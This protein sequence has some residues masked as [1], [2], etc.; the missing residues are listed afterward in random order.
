MSDD[1]LVEAD[2]LQ[3]AGDPLGE[4]IALTA[5]LGR[6]RRDRDVLGAEIRLLAAHPQLHTRRLL[7]R[8]RANRIQLLGRG[9]WHYEYR[10]RCAVFHAR[11]VELDGSTDERIA[12]VPLGH[13]VFRPRDT[14]RLMSLLG[15]EA[16][17]PHEHLVLC[18]AHWEACGVLPVEQRMD[19]ELVVDALVK[20][21]NEL[22]LRSSDEAALL[23]ALLR[24]LGE[25]SGLPPAIRLGD[26][27]VID[28]SACTVSAAYDARIEQST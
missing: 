7:T 12:V 27:A 19:W 6:D 10:H 22:R 26:G 23:D 8:I 24:I 13:L 28:M 14:A 15:A 21:T 9:A 1:V 16:A 5:A 25:L 20:P 11:L 17:D 3:E 4:L 2:A 18:H